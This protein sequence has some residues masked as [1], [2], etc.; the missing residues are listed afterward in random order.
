MLFLVLTKNDMQKLSITK[1]GRNSDG[2]PRNL[3]HPIDLKKICNIEQ[4][5]IT[6]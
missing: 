1:Q 4:Y 5:K 2:S 3:K 6:Y